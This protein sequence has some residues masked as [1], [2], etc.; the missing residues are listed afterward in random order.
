M[1]CKSCG[2]DV[3][4][5]LMTNYKK[6]NLEPELRCCEECIRSFPGTALSEL[7]SKIKDALN[8][9]NQDEWKD[10]ELSL[11]SAFALKMIQKENIEG[12][13]MG[14]IETLRAIT[15]SEVE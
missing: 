15:A 4:E 14:H 5:K 11:K 9:K 12:G 10:L 3:S 13:T 7:F 2:K 1:T 8:E 6:H